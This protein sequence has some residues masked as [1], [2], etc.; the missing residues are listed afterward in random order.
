MQL[1]FMVSNPLGSFSFPG[2]PFGLLILALG[3]ML[4]RKQSLPVHSGCKIQVIMGSLKG[5]MRGCGYVHLTCWF[6][7]VPSAIL[8]ASDPRDVRTE[9]TCLVWER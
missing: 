7:L 3:D 6:L 1:I 4:S 9:P 8:E 2:M 5:F